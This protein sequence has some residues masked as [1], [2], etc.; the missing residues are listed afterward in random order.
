MQLIILDE[1]KENIS[2]YA[3]ENR[4]SIAYLLKK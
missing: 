4:F 1:F 2:K 3:I